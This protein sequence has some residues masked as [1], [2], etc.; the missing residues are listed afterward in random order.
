MSA[1]IVAA[2]VAS[3]A[4]FACEA[5]YTLDAVRAEAEKEFRRTD[6]LQSVAT[7]GERVAVVGGQGTVVHS[8]DAGRTGKRAALVGKPALIDVAACPDGLFA[9]LDFDR[10]VWVESEPATWQRRPLP[11]DSPDLGL[12]LT[13]DPRGRLW[14]VGEFSTLWRSDDRGE[15]WATQSFDRDAILTAIEFVDE[16][17]AFIAGEFGAF[18]ASEDGGESWTFGPAVDAAEEFY[19]QDAAFRS[20]TEGWLVGLGGTVFHTSDA[21]QTWNLEPSAVEG[22]LF[23]LTLHDGEP[24]AVG[25]LGTLVRRGSGWQPVPLDPA[26][27]TT[28]SGVASIDSDHVIV[29][30]E[31][32]ECRRVPLSEVTR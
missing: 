23:G 5:Q 2:A 25:G 29:A 9:A 4:L 11:D 15:H 28:L 30:G 32:G 19:P 6:D 24:V 7:Q 1:R 12:A 10:A 18:L 26:V 21:G 14:V 13:C 16:S 17:T 22:P 31:G 20:P 27:F 3:F 8:E